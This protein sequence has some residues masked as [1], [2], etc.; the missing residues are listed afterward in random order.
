M[1]LPLPDSV[2][3]QMNSNQSSQKKNTVSFSPGTS[4]PPS[5]KEPREA[6][7]CKAPSDSYLQGNKRRRYQRRGSKSANLLLAAMVV[8]KS[9]HTDDTNVEESTQ[10]IAA[11]K[12]SFW[13]MVAKVGTGMD[14]QE[15][16]ECSCKRRVSVSMPRY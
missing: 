5:A 6:Q 8:R 10:K 7:S 1:T 11:D 4:R 9:E 12:A 13:A 14:L 2:A 15:R 3:L 16:D